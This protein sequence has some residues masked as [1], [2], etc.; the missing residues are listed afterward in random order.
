MFGRGLPLEISTCCRVICHVAEISS[1]WGA[2]TSDHC[3]D[4]SVA[5]AG[6]CAAFI[7]VT[8]QR[9]VLFLFLV[10]FSLSTDS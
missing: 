1:C 6:C 3:V 5:P 4:T 8:R 10:V 2:D 9:A 7:I